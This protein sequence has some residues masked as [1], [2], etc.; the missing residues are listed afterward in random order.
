MSEGYIKPRTYIRLANLAENARRHL[1]ITNIMNYESFAKQLREI[2]QLA[3]VVLPYDIRLI[4][5][6]ATIQ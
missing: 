1:I 6:R 3:A 5:E 4:G 2:P